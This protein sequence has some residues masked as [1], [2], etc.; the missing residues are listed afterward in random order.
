[1]NKTIQA[2]IGGI[3]F[4]VDE[5]AYQKLHA[6]LEQLKVY[7][8]KTEGTEDIVQDIEARVAE[9]IQGR[10]GKRAIVNKADVEAVIGAMGMPEDFEDTGTDEK[11]DRR[12]EQVIDTGKRFFRNTDNKIL[13]GV[14]SGISAYLNIDPLWLRLAFVLSFF[15]WGTG[16]LIYIILWI[17]IPEA[18]TT[19]DKMQMRGEAVNV[20]NI[21]RT[22]KEE[23]GKVGARLKGMAE[24]AKNLGSDENVQ[25]VKRGVGDAAESVG[26]ALRGILVVLGK[27][28]VVVMVVIGIIILVSLFVALA[29]GSAAVSLTFPFLQE[30]VFEN[31]LQGLLALTGMGLV[32]LV[33]LFW[34]ITRG[35][36]ALMKVKAGGW[37]NGS[38]LTLWM[39]AFVTVLLVGLRVGMDFR[40]EGIVA[41]EDALEIVT[42]DTLYVRVDAAQLHYYDADLQVRTT[43]RSMHLYISEFDPFQDSIRFSNIRLRTVST[44][45]STFSL[46]TYFSARGDN[47]AEA[48][49]RAEAITYQ[50]EVLDSLLLL[51]P[52]FDIGNE[53]WRNQKVRM[54]L[55]VPENRGVKFESTQ[56]KD[57]EGYSY[58]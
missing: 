31:T 40:Q 56:E 32:V 16:I 10:L 25:R 12:S 54:V 26:V 53:A 2:N 45:D 33:P 15:I 42:A 27:I 3:I 18:K 43:D 23:V 20:S 30:F 17:I 55:K 34:L 14:C 28:A 7:F 38:F 6:Y 50:V 57:H 44:A 51:P 24:D 13:G 8:R 22:V 47:A 58:W 5:D 29:S 48:R 19:I 1:M 9:I 35:I 39:I 49:T 52:Y 21:E 46:V 41:R 37:L 11:S 36:L 4:N